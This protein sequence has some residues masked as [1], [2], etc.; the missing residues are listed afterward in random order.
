[1][2][3]ISFLFHSILHPFRIGAERPRFA[4]CGKVPPRAR[5]IPVRDWAERPG[6]FFCAEKAVTKLPLVIP[7]MFGIIK[8]NIGSISKRRRGK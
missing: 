7:K 5:R 6:S 3:E 2:Q 4:F 8:P 1:M